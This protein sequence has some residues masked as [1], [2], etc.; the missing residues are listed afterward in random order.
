MG[1]GASKL[2]GLTQCRFNVGPP[3]ATLGWYHV[4]IGE[5]FFFVGLPIL[6]LAMPRCPEGWI[7]LSHHKINRLWKK[8]PIVQWSDRLAI[9]QWVCRFTWIWNH[10]HP[11]SLCHRHLCKHRL[12]WTRGTSW[13]GWDEWD[14]TALQTGGL[15]PSTL[16]F[17]HGSS[18]QS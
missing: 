12:N 16:P 10:P 15:R 6:R 14:K 9:S 3:S 17:G 8:T 11:P 13:G 4:N 7:H 1:W 5:A 18:S 2:K